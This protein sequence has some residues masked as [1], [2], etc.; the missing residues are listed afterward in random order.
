M[1][2]TVVTTPRVGDLQG[3]A[4]GTLRHSESVE[5]HSTITLPIIRLPIL[6]LQIQAELLRQ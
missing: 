5:F 2:A 1:V 4:M 6:Y 3:M